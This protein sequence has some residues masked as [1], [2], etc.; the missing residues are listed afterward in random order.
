MPKFNFVC[1]M[2]SIFLIQVY[3]II[4]IILVCEKYLRE[5]LIWF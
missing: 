3:L 2:K 4:I 5:L 1:E